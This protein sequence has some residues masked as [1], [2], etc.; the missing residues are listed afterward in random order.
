MF[1]KNAVDCM[2]KSG[3]DKDRIIPCRIM[4]FKTDLV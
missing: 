2:K 4:L 3:Y 1:V